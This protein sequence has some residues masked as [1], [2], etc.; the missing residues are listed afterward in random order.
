[1][2]TRAILDNAAARRLFLHRHA[3]GEPASGPARGDD[4]RAVIHRLG[5]VQIDS[6]NTVRRAHHMILHARRHAYRPNYLHP[7]LERDRTLFEHWTHDAAIIPTEFFGHWRLRFERNEIT[8]RAHWKKRR[9]EFEAR[10][11][12]VL[13]QIRAH[14]PVSSADVGSGE[15]RSSGGWWDWH[16]SKTAL[17][18]LWHTGQVMVTRRQGFRKLYDLTDRV[19]PAAALAHVPRAHDSI[20]WA[21]GAA[22][23][24]L[25][26]A[27]SG[28][29]AGFWAKVTPAEARAWCAHALKVGELTEIDVCGMDGSHRPHFARPDVIAAASEAP[30][31]PETVRILSPF[32]P[33]LRDRA[34]TRRLFDFDY[35]IEVFVPKAQRKY[36]YYVFPVLQGA[37]LIGRIDMKCERKDDVLAVT[38]FWPEARV[39]IGKN[40]LARLDSAIARTAAFAGVSEIRYAKGWLRT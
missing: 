33:A 12:P 26:F 23:D 11:G 16:P 28:E 30:D 38:A 7:L 32:D 39:A 8:L 18:Y 31:P 4:L 5:F 3:L 37:R 24:R 13:D 27:T 20:D 6:I 40:R 19:L 1:M 14:G 36:G 2:G 29:I 25:G 35:R 10:I 21:C 17:E 34:R 22:L 15:S 9:R